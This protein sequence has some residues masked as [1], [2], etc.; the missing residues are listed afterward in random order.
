LICPLGSTFFG[1]TPE[2]RKNL[3][4]QIHEIVFNGKGGY[5][6]T[7]VYNMPIWLRRFTFEKMKEFYAEEA[8]TLTP[9]SPSKKQTLGPDIKPNYSSARSKK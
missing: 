7:E 3:F 6:W 5:S 4:S 9:S 2:Y 8:K 1:L